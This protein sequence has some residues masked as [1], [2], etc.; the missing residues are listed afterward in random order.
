M[1]VQFASQLFNVPE[2]KRKSKSTLSHKPSPFF[3]PKQRSMSR[4]QRFLNAPAMNPVGPEGRAGSRVFI[5]QD[6]VMDSPYQTLYGLTIVPHPPPTCHKHHIQNRSSHYRIADHTADDELPHFIAEKH[7]LDTLQQHVSSR[8]WSPA[9]TRP[10]ATPQPQAR[11][12][13]VGRR[14]FVD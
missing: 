2:K 13:R 5:F 9:S 14:D 11:R 1:I 7:L 12:H 3:Q 8:D 6:E 4:S 10:N